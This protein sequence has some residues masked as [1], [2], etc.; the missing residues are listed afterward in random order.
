MKIYTYIDIDI[1]KTRLFCL[2]QPFTYDQIIV[3]NQSPNR[4]VGFC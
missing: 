1:C 2:G 3:F 4:T